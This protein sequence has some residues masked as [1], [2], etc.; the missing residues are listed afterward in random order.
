MRVLLDT[1]FII[2]CFRYRVDMQLLFD[3]FPGARLA[4]I[5][6]VVGELRRIAS[7]SSTQSRPAKVAMGLIDGIEVVDAPQGFVDDVLLG[8]ASKEDIVATNDER[9]RR[10]LHGKG[11]KTIYLRGRKHLAVS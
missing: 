2:D 10:R 9:L 8:L 1:N 5:P 7:K 3:I 6:Q 4:T 11:L